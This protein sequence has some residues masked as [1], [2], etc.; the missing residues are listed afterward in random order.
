[1]S[2]NTGRGALV[3][4]A[5]RRRDEAERASSRPRRPARCPA[6]RIAEVER[7]RCRSRPRDTCVAP[8]RPRR[9][10]RSNAASR[11][12]SDEPAASA[13][14]R[15]PAP[16]RGSP[17]SGRASGISVAHAIERER[18]RPARAGQHAGL[19]RVDE[20]LPARLDDV[21]GDADRAPGVAGRRVASSSTRV[22]APVPLRSSRMRTLK[23]DE[24][25]V[26]QVRVALGER[27]VAVP[28][29]A[30]SPGRCPRR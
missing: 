1:M 21:L 11:G 15:A 22:T 28:S 16:P 9:R 5:V 18:R 29:R 13:A 6:A 25:D 17:M 12:P 14:S 30:R 19:E 3:E 4:Q 26:A 10:L 2:Q 27:A 24:L 8:S 23:F 7:R 20:R